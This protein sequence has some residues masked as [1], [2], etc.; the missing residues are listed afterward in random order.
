MPFSNHDL[1][2]GWP[3]EVLFRVFWENLKMK[4][5]SDEDGGR[6]KVAKL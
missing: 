2:D 3:T 6:I 4:V 5:D 1:E